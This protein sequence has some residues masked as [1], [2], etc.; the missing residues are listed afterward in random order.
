MNNGDS[1]MAQHKIKVFISSTFQDMQ[2]ERDEL[3]LRVFPELRARC[4]EIGIE[5]VDVD[6]RWGITEE[7]ERNGDVLPICLKQIDESR[8]F[9]I[10][11]VGERYGSI[12]THID[13]D[14]LQANPWLR[15]QKGR[16]L[17]ELEIQHGALMNVA[18]AQHAF[19]YFR[20][21]EYADS[22]SIEER[23]KFIENN[24]Q[25]SQKLNE[26]KQKICD[27]GFPVL[28]GYG[29]PVLLGN[30][31]LTDLWS[32]I[33]TEYAKKSAK[34]TR[35]NVKT[36]KERSQ[37]SSTGTIYIER[38]EEQELN[39]HIDSLKGG[40][41][42]VGAS[43]FGKT[44]LLKEWTKKIPQ[45]H[46][47]YL[48]FEHYTENAEHGIEFEDL[49]KRLF[50]YIKLKVIPDLEISL[51][52]RNLL[53]MLYPILRR[54][55][56]RRPLVIIIDGFDQMKNQGKQIDLSIL[57][58]SFPPNVSAIIS[59]RPGQIFET[60]KHRGWQSI[61]LVPISI[62]QRDTI[63]VRYLEQFGKQLSPNRR[64]LIL[65]H[66]LSENPQLLRLF[67][68]EL[69]VGARHD[70]LNAKIKEYVLIKDP[71]QLFDTILEHYEKRLDN[72]CPGLLKNAMVL[73][74]ASRSGLQETELLDLL[75]T[76]GTPL[77]RETWSVLFLSFQ[78]S[79]ILQGE[80]IRIRYDSLRE[81]I[82]RRYLASAEDLS[83]VQDSLITYFK[84]RKYESRGLE[85]LPWQLY[86]TRRYN[87][88]LKLLTDIKIFQ[89][90]S[91]NLYRD[92][93]T[94]WSK[95]KLH[96][97]ISSTMEKILVDFE[98]KEKSQMQQGQFATAIGQF[99]YILGSYSEAV[100]FY[101]H[102]K[103]R[104]TS[105]LGWDSSAVAECLLSI[106]D[107]QRKLAEFD[108]AIMNNRRALAIFLK[109]GGIENESSVTALSGLAVSLAESKN[110]SAKKVFQYA[111]ALSTKIK[112]RKHP[113]T[114]ILLDNMAGYLG[115]VKEGSDNLDMH[116]E[117]LALIE[118]SCGYDSIH[119]ATCIDNLA[120][121]LSSKGEL[122]E[123]EN[124]FRR[125]LK[126]WEQTV[127]ATHP[128][129]QIA[130][131]SLFRVLIERNDLVGA[132]NIFRRRLQCIKPKK[133]ADLGSV[134]IDLAN[135]T[136]LLIHKSK[137]KEAALLHE[138]YISI[139][140]LNEAEPDRK[141]L[142]RF[143]DIMHSLGKYEKSKQIFQR[144]LSMTGSNKS[145][146]YSVKAHSM[147]GLAK[148]ERDS[149]KIHNARNYA[150]EALD[151]LG[152]S[153]ATTIDRIE[154][155]NL[156]AT[157]D[158]Q[159]DDL[160]QADIDSQM[161]IELSEKTYGK[162]KLQTA[163]LYDLRC[164]VLLEKGDLKN[165]D[166]FSQ[167]AVKL[168]VK[169]FGEEH[170]N[171]L[172][173]L[174]NRAMAHY[175]M[176]NLD[177]AEGL[178]QRV[179][180]IRCRVLGDHHPSTIGTLRQLTDVL[181][182]K[183]AH[184]DVLSILERILKI[185]KKYRQSTN[186]DPVDDIFSKA[187][188]L[189]ELKRYDEAEKTYMQIMEMPQESYKEKSSFRL[190]F[191]NLG[192]IYEE[193]RNLEKAEAC[194]RKAFEIAGQQSENE[195]INWRLGCMADLTRILLK[196]SQLNEAE[197]LAKQALDIATSY[198]NIDPIQPGIWLREIGN[199]LIVKGEQFQAKEYLERSLAVFTE[200]LGKDH[201]ETVKLFKFLSNSRKIDNFDDTAQ[202]VSI[203]NLGEESLKNKNFDRAE[204]L[205][206]Q[207]LTI[208]NKKFEKDHHL[209]GRTLS[210]MT[211]VLISQKRFNEAESF[212]KNCVKI[213]KKTCGENASDTLI[214]RRN[215][216]FILSQKGNHKEAAYQFK[217]VLHYQEKEK[218]LTD[219]VVLNTAIH[220]ARS[221][222]F[223]QK[224]EET[225][226]LLLGIVNANKKIFSQGNSKAVSIF[227]PI[228]NGLKEQFIDEIA[229]PFLKRILE[230]VPRESALW[231]LLGAHVSYL[232]AVIYSNS[233][234]HL[235]AI[236]H[237]EGVLEGVSIFL[238]PEQLHSDEDLP[239]LPLFW[240]S[241]AYRELARHKE[242]PEG[243]WDQA[244]EYFE[245]S[246]KILNRIGYKYQANEVELELQIMR[247]K[248]G[249]EVKYIDVKK[250]TTWFEKT[251]KSTLKTPLI[252]LATKKVYARPAVKFN[253]LALI[254]RKQNRLMEAEDLLR[255]A[256]SIEEMALPQ[257]SPKIPHRLNNLTTVLVMQ[258]K[259]EEAMDLNNRA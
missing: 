158:L 216:A 74:W 103:K 225:V 191:P 38:I 96:Y 19:F 234:K 33:E 17:T 8:P 138:E 47:D 159:L 199:I 25:Y 242:V 82:S 174:H 9:F 222:I 52:P 67:L 14:L 257:D 113:G 253:E 39:S 162:N 80:R 181:K 254:F 209:F 65:D 172:S 211:G 140:D 56:E 27:A 50:E 100:Y 22:V 18:A 248:I 146:E 224:K 228:I 99:L 105:A 217:I 223:L 69:R 129:T 40:L 186:A 49:I 202:V 58:V 151:L 258:D 46:S 207:A 204:E 7:Q 237:Y 150:K 112:G 198:Q 229:E 118:D 76:N 144:A 184:E 120:V 108:D 179:A 152:E 255:Q 195:S 114:A 221:M 177:K 166:I 48:I 97:D 236:Y 31:V 135:L 32:V 88:L 79:L 86:E 106:G 92:F 148:V 241:V 95:L 230:L 81:A 213:S 109:L 243:R 93:I 244:I 246:I 194:Y 160:H 210:L 161:A 176:K 238:E 171:T 122:E 13:D 131:D 62:E 91:T 180:D 147:L 111:L 188:T 232:L 143:G 11:I 87:Q 2:P 175:A 164:R 85:E 233:G 128:D 75:G 20:S 45:T 185:N 119:T 101:Q 124:L 134:H 193:Q 37:A 10:G 90:I 21:H 149:G 26:L 192:K 57:P 16:S 137:I 24:P 145:Q 259:Q 155:F 1:I 102:S 15:F 154:C 139:L 30:H 61:E 251:I 125:A 256:L 98:S 141:I 73:L 68:E 29:D 60:L 227:Y 43:G 214:S 132:V 5:L 240:A 168:L 165:A 203:L 249:R 205:I 239:E 178:L 196:S 34:K 187:E 231:P 220:L 63:I 201:D 156:L 104:L 208:C 170:P 115:R 167:K 215:L 126:I 66:H 197:D 84:K 36:N 107:V 206:N 71:T 127:G 6:L 23:Y 59:M 44:A 4:R 247:S 42:V 78:E 163:T 218:G 250:I 226:D 219:T 12:P 72:Y 157:I 51:S 55:G 28:K 64:R 173:A 130:L 70:N 169:G 83:A 183:G 182:Q 116:R 121:A 110:K 252:P 94:Y 123:A 53:L 117:A 54:V 41:G 89:K 77:K 3:T 133:E 136:L 235:K 200:E 245:L 35:V 153:T 142:N 212:A 190:C 189:M